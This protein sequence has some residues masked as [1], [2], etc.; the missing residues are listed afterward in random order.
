MLEQCCRN[1]R[2]EYNADI[3]KAAAQL[4]DAVGPSC[5]FSMVQRLLTCQEQETQSDGRAAA[6]DCAE[7]MHPRNCRVKEAR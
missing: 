5:Y 3:V 4:T 7:T 1:R 2:E 6:K